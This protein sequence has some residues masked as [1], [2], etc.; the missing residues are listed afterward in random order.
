M[1]LPY[2]IVKDSQIRGIHS[3]HCLPFGTYTMFWTP[4]STPKVRSRACL[5]FVYFFPIELECNCYKFNINSLLTTFNCILLF[6]SMS[7]VLSSA[8]ILF[9]FNLVICRHS[10]HIDVFNDYESLS[11]S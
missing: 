3:N 10:V 7:I 4:M 9:H 6:D 11:T 2:M 1:N 8:S 5:L